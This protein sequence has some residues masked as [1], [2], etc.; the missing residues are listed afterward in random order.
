MSV[1]MVIDC[2]TAE[3]RHNSPRAGTDGLV[4]PELEPELSGNTG[5]ASP[6]GAD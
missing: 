4:L 6:S 1:C 2:E 5:S 3:D